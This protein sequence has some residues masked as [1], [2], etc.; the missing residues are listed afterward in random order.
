[1]K[2]GKSVLFYGNTKANKAVFYAQNFY[3]LKK[4]RLLG[5]CKVFRDLVTIQAC[6]VN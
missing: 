5:F 4:A 2:Y 1:M 3:V 6:A